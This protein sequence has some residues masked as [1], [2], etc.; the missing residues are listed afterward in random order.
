VRDNVLGMLLQNGV[1]GFER[2]VLFEFRDLL[3]QLAPPLVV[4]VAAG[5]GFR[6]APEP[7]QKAL[8][9]EGRHC[10]I[11]S[12]LASFA[13]LGP[14]CHLFEAR[15]STSEGVLTRTDSFDLLG[16]QCLQPLRKLPP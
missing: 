12:E 8:R 7:G 15:E 2:I 4:Q 14:V 3:I 9:G 1:F 10:S 13:M 11:P 16:A 5:D 6:A